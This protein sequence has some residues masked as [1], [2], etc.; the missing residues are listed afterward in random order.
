MDLISL[1]LPRSSSSGYSSLN[2]GRATVECLDALSSLHGEKAE[3]S[4]GAKTG[5]IAEGCAPRVQFRGKRVTLTP[6]SSRW[7]A[8]ELRFIRVSPRSLHISRP[9]LLTLRKCS[10]TAR[11]RCC[12]ESLACKARPEVASSSWRENCDFF[13]SQDAW[14]PSESQDARSSG[15]SFNPFFSWLVTDPIAS[16]TVCTGNDP[17]DR[18]SWRN[19]RNNF[20]AHGRCLEC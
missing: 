1:P 6:H 19:D 10:A 7:R 17:A 3:G 13:E 15:H 11:R 8:R 18:D 5:E 20:P 2:K 16:T 12:I 14:V 4:A 9:L